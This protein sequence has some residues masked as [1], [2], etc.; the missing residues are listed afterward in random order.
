MSW[1]E[2]ESRSSIA[3]G[4]KRGALVLGLPGLAVALVGRDSDLLGCDLAGDHRQVDLVLVLALDEDRRP[5]LERA[6]KHEVGERILDETLDRAAQRPRA[7]RRVVAL[8]DQ[9][10]FRGV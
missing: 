7:H 6:P 2:N 4:R 8:V 10:V 3:P 5:R 9:Q 1:R